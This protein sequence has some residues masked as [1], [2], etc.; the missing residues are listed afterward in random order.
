[1]K[2]KISS[3][4]ETA[5]ASEEYDWFCLRTQT[6]R[7]HI[8]AAMLQQIEAVESFCP[9]VSQLRRTRAGKRRFV[10]AMFPGYIFARFNLSQKHR[11]VTHT[12]GVKYLVKHGNRL[13]IPDTI[14]ESLRASLPNDMIEAP[15]LSIEEGANIELISGSLQGLNGTVLAQL[16]AENRVQVLLDFLGREITVAVSADSVMLAED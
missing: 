4:C 8:A 6:K 9:R 3:G 13:A 16:P 2:T 5:P 1:M 14:I 12:Q 15:D 10:E 7:E 11:H